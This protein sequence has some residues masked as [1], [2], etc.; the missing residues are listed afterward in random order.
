M[1]RPRTVHLVDD[2]AAVRSSLGGLLALCGFQVRPYASGRA[3]LDAAAALQEGCILLDLRMPDLSGLEVQ[4]E[5][6]RLAIDL[7]VIFL[8]AHGDV[9]TG[10]SAMKRG[11]HDFLL[12]PVREE[13]LLDALEHAFARFDA[14]AVR[15]DAVRRARRLLATVTPRER[16]VIAL[17]AGGMRNRE[18]AAR[19]DISLQTVKVHRMRAMAKLEVE[20]MPQ[21]TRVWAEATGTP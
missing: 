20:T 19:L 12:K 13:V 14:Q 8:T 21:L 18:I 4:A 3:L 2:D 17:V 11:A 16:E 5:L 1:T 7:P 9:P 15:R 6:A 10:V